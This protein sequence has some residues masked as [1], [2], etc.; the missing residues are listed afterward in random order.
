MRLRCL[1]GLACLLCVF[2]LVLAYYWQ[3]SLHLE[4]CPL[5]LMQRALFV[6]LAVIFFIHWCHQPSRLCLHRWYGAVILLIAGAGIV[7]SGR[8]VWLQ[9]LPADQ[10][11]PC[12]ASLTYMFAHFPLGEL[13]LA[14]FNGHG[15]C[16]DIIMQVWGFSLAQWSLVFFIGLVIIGCILFSGYTQNMSRCKEA[17]NR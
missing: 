13:L 12:G 3:W 8:Q 2:I 9:H 17:E 16:A 7:I 10:Q 4:P 14:L 6:L 5:C 15:N 1:S 11:P